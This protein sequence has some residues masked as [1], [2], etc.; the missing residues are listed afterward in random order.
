MNPELRPIVGAP[1]RRIGVY[2]LR[3]YLAETLAGRRLDWL[4]LLGE[5]VHRLAY[6]RR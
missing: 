2:I 1:L 6:K 4:C 3:I 5:R